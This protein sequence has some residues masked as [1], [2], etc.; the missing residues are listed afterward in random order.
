MDIVTQLHVVGY[1][2]FGELAACIPR[3]RSLRSE[4]A[5]GSCMY[6]DMMDLVS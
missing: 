1:Y 6:L 5:W 4:Q 3:R 2:G